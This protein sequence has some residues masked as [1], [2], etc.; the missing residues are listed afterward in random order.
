MRVPSS[1]A[2]GRRAL[3]WGAATFLALQLTAGVLLDYRWPEVRFPFFYETAAR[4]DLFAVPPSIVCLGSSRF[5]CLLDEMEVTRVV[6]QLTGDPAV[7][8]F[9]ASVGA[10]D[11]V[12]SEKMLE[13]L[14]ARGLQPRYA[15]VELSPES[16]NHLNRWLTLHVGRQLRWDEVP[17]YFVE[18]TRTGNLMRLAGTRLL[19]LHVYR[20]Q[21]RG[22]FVGHTR[23]WYEELIRGQAAHRPRQGDEGLPTT[24]TDWAKLVADGLG[25]GTAVAGADTT[26]DLA[27]LRRELDA[28][29]PGGNSAAALERLLRR[30]RAH[31]VE[32]ILLAVPLASAHR[33]EYDGAV[34]ARFQEYMLRVTRTY[35][36]RFLDYRATLPD[37]FF[38]D[39]HHATPQAKLVFSRKVGLEVLAPAWDAA[40][41]AG[42]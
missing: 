12:V 27:G 6:R 39:H 23:D 42:L 31:G 41:R 25:A 2:R 37:H 35:G 38:L 21:I 28:Y 11:L 10:G 22:Y 5:G 32:P 9:N 29:R 30:C 8:A 15:L 36:C 24:P 33:G 3:A 13:R 34:E 20:N 18:V 4:P 14:L 16:V 1:R 40:R 17:G 7:Q 19:P 26:R